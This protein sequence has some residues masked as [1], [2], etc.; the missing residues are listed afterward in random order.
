[1]NYRKKF[2]YLV[3]F[4][5]C[6]CQFAMAQ[7]INR[8]DRLVRINDSIFIV[9]N[10]KRYLADR[11]VVTVKLKPEVSRIRKDLKELRSNRLG[12]I[13]LSV[14]EGVDIEDYVAMLEK[15]GDFEV[16][17][18]N[19]LGELGFTPNDILI[20]NQW[21]LNSINAY[22]AW[23]ITKGNS[24]VIVAILDTG[25]DWGHPDLGNGADGYSNVNAT[26]GWNYLNG[27][28]NVITTYGHGTK[29]A[30][31]IGAK[32][33]NSIGI[34]GISGGNNSSGVTIIPLC[35]STSVVDLSVT[36]DAIIDAVDNGARVI[37]MSFG[38]PSSTALDAAIAYA[39][40]NNVVLVACSMNYYSSTVSYPASHQDVIAV[41]AIDQ[42]NN[43]AD[44]SNYGTNLDV[45]APGVGILSTILNNDY[46]KDNGTSFAAPQV[47]A[48]AALILSVRPDLNA[49]QVRNAIETTCNKSLPGWTVTQTR[50]NGTWNDQFGYG[51]VNA[52][53]A[54]YSVAPRIS[55][56]SSLCYG[57]SS[58][59]TVTNP[60][61]SYTWT[62]SSNLTQGSA[63]GDSKMFTAN[64]SDNAWVA[65]NFGSI[66]VARYNFIVNSAPVISYIDGPDNVVLYSTGSS[67]YAD[68]ADYTI[69]L[70]NTNAPPYSY[71]WS[72]DGNSSYYSLS[73][74]G[75]TVRVTF[76]I[77]F[78]W[79]FKL[80]AYAY[81]SCGNDYMAKYITFSD[82]SRSTPKVY[83]NPASDILNIEIDQE[84]VD[85]VIARQQ[86]SGA[87]NSN[88]DPVFDIR[89]YDGYGVML[90][91][92]T[93]KG[94]IV[95]FDVS[96]LPNGTYY[97][98][99][100][101]GVGS[102]PEKH[103]VVVE[104]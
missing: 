23:D 26:L 27:N 4:A 5:L 56:P 66:E 15:T 7:L 64:N 54:V 43:R 57:Q 69:V 13:D 42:S 31:I 32:T 25:V 14:P 67:T 17:E 39:V 48:I 21:Y 49:Q 82:G 63:S 104:H 70:S 61:A 62:C 72:V 46:D 87:L 91:S 86:A 10:G 76:N 75:N 19:G 78:N 80:N 74:N 97:L 98:H 3:I 60:P 20:S 41:G 79:S 22:T 2:V 12:Y 93:T 47:S 77:D 38:G 89:L 8:N 85:D 100:Y 73:Q 99:I 65:V 9:E 71:S 33:H 88:A 16:V 90:R 30:G 50:S 28:N 6:L 95:Q 36:D 81:N 59:F 45:V 52:Y 35:I 44:F 40:Q 92:T 102:Q 51:L 101:D 58:T 18:Y 84:T 68:Y 83:P 34:A 1:M 29:V 103:Q 37:N 94:G 96:A 53:E 24:N 11:N 55:G